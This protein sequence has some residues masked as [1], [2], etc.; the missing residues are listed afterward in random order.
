MADVIDEAEVLRIAWLA[1]LKLSAEEV[2][3]LVSELGRIVDYFGQ[4]AEVDV[5]GV[6]PLAHPLCMA[7]VQRDDEP[8]PCLG[9]A[10][11][12]SNAPAHEG[13]LFKVPAILDRPAAHQPPADGK[14]ETG[15]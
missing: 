10:I 1:R 7:D 5:S 2:R 11:A 15:G 9:A 6:Q 3:T 14:T 8:R 13:G 4:L 12:L